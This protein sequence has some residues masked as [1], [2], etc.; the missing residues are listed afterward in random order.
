MTMAWVIVNN[1]PPPH[2]V[3]LKPISPADEVK[4]MVIRRMSQK[5]WANQEGRMA[6]RDKEVEEEVRNIMAD[7]DSEEKVT[8][9]SQLADNDKAMLELQRRVEGERKRPSKRTMFRTVLLLRLPT[10]HPVCIH[11][12]YS[13]PPPP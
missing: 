6:T 2:L 11:I 12:Y 10:G 4:G 5:F 8:L 9:S 1:P 3:L 7:N 13:S